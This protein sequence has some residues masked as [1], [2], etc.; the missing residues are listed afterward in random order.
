MKQLL[1]LP[2][3]VLSLSCFAQQFG[4]TAQYPV[5]KIIPDSL[6]KGYVD[7]KG[8]KQG[9]F[10]FYEEESS[11][12]HF[13]R[14]YRNDT[15]NGFLGCYSPKGF[16]NSEQFRKN[17]LKDGFEFSY[18]E[19]NK[20]ESKGFYKDDKK[21]GIFLEFYE[22]GNLKSEE[23]YQNDSLVGDRISYHANKQVWGIGNRVNGHYKHY[24]STG[25]L[26]EDETFEN[27]RRKRIQVYYP[28]IFKQ[29]NHRFLK[30]QLLK[31]KDIKNHTTLV[32]EELFSNYSDRNDLLSMEG[33]AP[34]VSMD[35][36]IVAIRFDRTILRIQPEGLSRCQGCINYDSDK[37]FPISFFGLNV[38]ES[39]NEQHEYT[40]EY[41]LE[42]VH[43]PMKNFEVIVHRQKAQ[44]MDT[45]NNP[46]TILHKG[47][48][49]E[50]LNLKNILFF[51]FDADKN[52]A[53]E[54]Y[55]ISYQSCDGLY[56]ILRVK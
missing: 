5:Y 3:L 47:K 4:S 7:A 9:S 45:G 22:N 11:K 28:Q 19:Q 40:Y 32:V 18:Y 34:D 14:T 50:L 46:V 38:K 29:S 15:L 56:K 36:S 37:N 41:V 10:F 2:L 43:Y 12:L 49:L 25:F 26:L 27:E 16:V 17:G 31:S 42:D 24:D 55:I 52:G 54:L 48:K 20:I 30:A 23:F 39:E 1:V 53:D 33:S 21:H 35:D 51:P 6:D 8:L 13:I 44:C